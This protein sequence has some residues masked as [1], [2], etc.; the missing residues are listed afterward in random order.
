MLTGAFMAVPVQAATNRE[1]HRLVVV[2]TE[3]PPTI[4]GRLDEPMWQEAGVVDRFTQQEPA[5]GDAATERTEVRLLY[6]RGH[7]FI[8]VRAFDSDPAGIVAT[9]MRR[10]SNRLLDEDSFQIIIDTFNDSRSGY[11]FVTNPLGAKLEQQ[12]FEEGEGSTFGSNSNVNRN[13]DGVW[14]VVSRRTDEGWVAEIAIPMT[15]L[16]FRPDEEQTWGVNFM[17][18]IRRKNESSFWAPIPKAY[19]LT[20]VSLAGSLTGMQGLSQGLDLRIKPFVVAGARGD[21][22]GHS[23]DVSGLN[24]VGLDVK[25]GV[26]SGLNLDLTLNTDFAQVEVDEQQVN[27]TRFSLFFPEKREFFLENANQFN[28]GTRFQRSADLF[29]SRRIGL[30]DTGQPVPIVAGA[31]LT[32]KAGRN[33]LA[34]MD[35]QTDGAFETQ[36]ENFFVARYSRD[37]LS[38]SKV[39]G[40]FINKES[41]D[42]SDFNR[43]MAVDANFAIGNHFTV[44]SFLAKT[45]SPNVTTGD[46]AF[47]GRVAWLDPAWNVWAEYTDIQDN[48]NA[49]VGFV[50]R[51]GIR[52]TQLN[53]IRTPRPKRFNIRTML[54]M[55]NYTY[56][57]DQQNRLVTRRAHYMVGFMMQNGAFINV[58]YNRLLEVLD[59][60]F[61]LS[62]NVV[63][64]IGTYRFGEAVFTYNSDPSR[65]I[66]QRFEYSPQTFFEGTR[67]DVNAAVGLRATN[68]LA[69][70]LQYTHNDVNLPVGD[71]KID[72]AILRLDYALSPRAT[73]RSLIQYNSSVDE[74]SASVR[75]N[76]RYTPGSDLYVAYDELRDELGRQTFTKNRQLVLKLTYLLSR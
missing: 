58:V 1:D 70:E 11:M 41:I 40:L 34:M 52:T 23:L 14:N 7:L 76:L 75:F 57:T 15:T 49:E 2:R 8:G 73:I 29:F 67:T 28:V 38:R 55:F 16:R 33:N 42:G 18:L 43:T 31:R 44:N 65:R 4:D 32:G 19:G 46:K 9:E 50:P 25:Y 5:E 48:F 56:T 63:V 45:S 10:D 24:D 22:V 36:G 12:I 51:Q 59:R 13:W 27:L 68:Q 74:M 39:G 47:Y 26:T 54:P 53:I 71:L 3:T 17:R 72:L 62:P 6:D 21:R 61:R 66:Y 20:R 35:I 69:A 64:P 60:P 30:S 37:V